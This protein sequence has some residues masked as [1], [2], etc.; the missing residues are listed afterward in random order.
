MEQTAELS[1]VDHH[2]WRRDQPRAHDRLGPRRAER[3]F[4]SAP[5]MQRQG[6][7]R[8]ASA[9]RPRS[10][11][12]SSNALSLR[13]VAQLSILAAVALLSPALALLGFIA[14]EI[15]IGV[16]V[17]A[18]GPSLPAFI[19]AGAVGWLLLRKLW[20]P[21]RGRPGRGVS[22]KLRA[23]PCEIPVPAES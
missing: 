9:L 12:A 17:D 2:H 21:P 19:A 14:V 7:S 8:T 23:R 5:V 11:L 15:V 3:R 13:E 20:R 10:V 18:G 4:S 1:F 22:T 6:G 16:L